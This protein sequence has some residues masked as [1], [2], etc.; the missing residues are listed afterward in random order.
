MQCTPNS[1]C[2]GGWPYI[3]LNTISGRGVPLESQYPYKANIKAY[4]TNQIC[5]EQLLTTLP[6]EVDL[7]NH[8][9]S[10]SDKQLKQI[11][12][13]H[14]PVSVGIKGSVNGFLYYSGGV[15]SGCDSITSE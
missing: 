3:A 4:D 9:N 8:Y 2:S 14:G 12:I 1:T 6:N 7:I 11:L 13:D 5:S 10:I 15:F